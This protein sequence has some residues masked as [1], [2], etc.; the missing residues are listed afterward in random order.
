MLLIQ[1]KANSGK[2]RSIDTFIAGLIS[3]YVVFGDRNAI[4]EQV[5]FVQSP[6]WSSE[7]KDSYMIDCFI[8]L[9]SGGR[10]FHPT[11]NVTIF[12]DIHSLFRRKTRPAQRPSFLDIRSGMLGSRHVAIHQQRRDDSTGNVQLHDISVPRFKSLEQSPNSLV[13]QQIVSTYHE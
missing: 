13:A 2:E 4:N 11:S 9:L 6:L 7:L 1:K 10:L 5:R 8:R 12:H 3:G